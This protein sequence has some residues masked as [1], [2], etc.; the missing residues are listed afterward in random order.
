MRIFMIITMAV[1]LSY[2]ANGQTC[3]CE[4]NFEWVKKTFENNDA[5]F[6]YIINKKGEAAYDIHNQLM[7]EKIKAA[8]TSTE[9]SKLLYEW[10]TFFRFGHIGIERLINET[11]DTQDVPQTVQ[12]PETWKVDIPQF[13]KYI[14]EKI[15]ADY[16]GIWETGAYK[17]GIKKDG[18]NYV[19]FIIESDVDGWREPG[20]VKLK[21]EQ[22]GDKL[23]TTYYMRDH[24]PVISGEPEWMGNNCLQAGA[25]TLKRLKPLFQDDPSVEHYFK[26]MDSRTPYLETLNET[27]LYL[28]IPSFDHNE[29]HAID[30][31]IFANKEHILKTENL[32]IDIRNGT[33]GS[34]VSY[35]ELL[36]FLYT[37]PIRTVG[38]EFLST[39]QNNQRFLD[40]A[41]DPEY[42]DFF[43]EA[44]RQQ[45]KDY[46]EKLSNNLGEFVDLSGE[47]VSIT[48]FDT[49]YEYPKNV[50]IIINKGN[51]STDE[52]FLLAAKQSKKV[53]LFGATTFGALDISNMYSIDSPCKEF[54]L[55]YC[56][57]RSMR[58][59][60]MAIDD[61]G[62]QPDYYLD[63]TI[64]QYKWVE[65][66]N[67]VLNHH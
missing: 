10:L 39:V 62:L 46:Y 51:G 54:R 37:N 49:V 29:K 30:S 6:Q 23:K 40:F 59:P 56:L 4:S 47:S 28:R 21:I 24:S 61:I 12:N 5:G 16:E 64:P 34:D 27:T 1:V 25:Q 22:D 35:H 20:L 36:P 19:G 52:Q 58:L 33:G 38:V 7:L 50:G 60:D 11:P 55:W 3:T 53:K 42:Q 63:K 18:V 44:T 2:S 65:F 15:V 32:I 14:S 31:V 48:Q 67:D 66:V 41:T 26:F 17:I 9:C 45:L 57:S 43:D 13:E 8:K